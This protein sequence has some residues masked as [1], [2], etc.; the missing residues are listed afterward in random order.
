MDKTNSI[1]DVVVIGA[2][3][4]GMM[5][6]GTA[7]ATG[8]QVLLIEKNDSLGKKLL[9]TGG[10]RCNLTNAEF[11]NR[12]LLAKFKDSDKFLFSAFAKWSVQHT[13]DFF[14]QHQL[15]TKVE[16]EGRVFPVSNK[17]QSVWD[18][19]VSELKNHNV[20]ILSNSPVKK[21]LTDQGRITGVQ[22]KNNTIITSHSFILATGGQSRP[23]T[24]STGDGF[25]WLEELGHQVT[26]PSTALVPVSLKN[27]WLKNL[28][29]ISLPDVKITIFQ[30]GVKQAKQHGKILFT[31]FGVTGPTI[32]NMSREIGELLKYGEV[33]MTID[34][35]PN[36]AEDKLNTE[37]VATL[38]QDSNK[39]IKNVLNLLIPSGLVATI[40]ELAQINPDQPCHSVTRE[41][42]LKLIKTLKHLPAEVKGLLGED[43]AVTSSGGVKLTEVD[44][45]TM[46]SRHYSNL[47]II[48]DLLDINR[49]SGGYSLQLCWTTGHVAGEASTKKPN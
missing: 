41:E 39:K 34:T 20:E 11:D 24:G 48:G 25:K 42:R 37:L 33:S 47:Y 30:N 12:K 1:Y 17:S 5:A 21:I 44:F 13:L 40:L 19:L 6:A 8:A 45:R 2:G 26:P 3:P 10:G 9:I 29:G 23:E 4:A 18:V 31:H 32:L 36:L 14:H 15:D 27:S 49:P 43:K 28:Q 46:Q 16:A 7:A 38:H 22:L 35:L